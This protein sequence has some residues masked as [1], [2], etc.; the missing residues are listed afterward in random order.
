MFGTHASGGLIDEASLS[1]LK[2]TLICQVNKQTHVRLTGESLPTKPTTTHGSGLHE[3]AQLAAADVEIRMQEY[4]ECQCGFW[5]Y[6]ASS[7][8][9]QVMMDH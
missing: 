5:P 3:G 2:S 4:G 6:G 8:D 9:S 7:L 1:T